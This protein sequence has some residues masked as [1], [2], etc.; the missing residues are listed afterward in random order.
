MSDN[1][2]SI[3]DRLRS[4]QG[5]DTVDEQPTREKQVYKAVEIEKRDRRVLRMQVNF[6]DGGIDLCSYA[7][8]ANIYSASNNRITLIYTSGV[9]Y[10]EGENLRSLLADFQAEHVHAVHPF[11]PARHKT[12]EKDAPLIRRID[13]QSPEQ[14]LGKS[15]NQ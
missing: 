6:S 10:L 9:V 13:W 15:E 7:Q 12:P 8:L 14:V 4:K 11:D 2:V 3:F 1:V 5:S